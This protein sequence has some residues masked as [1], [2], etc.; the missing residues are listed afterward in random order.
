MGSSRPPKADIS[1]VDSYAHRSG[2]NARLV[3]ADPRVEVPAEA[4]ALLR[5]RKAH[6]ELEVSCG[7]I[8]DERGRRLVIQVPLASLRD[9][10]WTIRLRTADGTSSLGCRLLVQ[11]DRPLVLLWGAKASPSI[12]PRPHP[13]SPAP[14]GAAD[15][16]RLTAR[17]LAGAVSRRVRR[18]A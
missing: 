9:G 6:A 12:L 10:I 4:T 14:A 17:R 8:D 7:L 11:G 18:S 15:T 16:A 2:V 13:R 3:L 1:L 5:H